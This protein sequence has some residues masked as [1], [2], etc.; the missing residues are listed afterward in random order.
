MAVKYTTYGK[1]RNGSKIYI[2]GYLFKVTNLR[3]TKTPKGTVIRFKGVCTADER[4]DS[5]RG[6]M[7]NGGTYGAYDWV[8]A[9]IQ[10]SP[11]KRAKKKGG[12]RCRSLS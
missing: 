9:T 11:S 5:I 1:L 2:Q 10:T 4:N 8:R 6:T 12:R 7:Y 3:R